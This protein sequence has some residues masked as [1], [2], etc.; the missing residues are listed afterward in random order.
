MT[1][2]RNNVSKAQVPSQQEK[3][4]DSYKGSGSSEEEKGGLRKVATRAGTRYGEEKGTAGAQ[5]LPSWEGTR[6]KGEEQGWGK[7]RVW[8]EQTWGAVAEPRGLHGPGS[9]KVGIP[10]N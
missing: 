3:L 4:S 9:K 7:M 2:Q 8:P 6:V 10:G 1:L 5:G